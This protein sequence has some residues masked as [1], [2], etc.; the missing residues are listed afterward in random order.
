[1]QKAL[2]VPSRMLEMAYHGDFMSNLTAD[3]FHEERTVWGSWLISHTQKSHSLKLFLQRASII[4]CKIAPRVRYEKFFGGAMGLHPHYGISVEIKFKRNREL[5][6][7]LEL[8]FQPDGT[9]ASESG[10]V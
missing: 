10:P 9:L 5:V 4:S 2:A 7:D 3:K 6:G 1:M 8:I